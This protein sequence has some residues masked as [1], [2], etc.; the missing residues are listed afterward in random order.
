MLSLADIDL[1]HGV[2]TTLTDPKH[3]TLDWSKIDAKEAN[4]PAYTPVSGEYLNQLLKEKL[5][6]QKEKLI[7][8]QEGKEEKNT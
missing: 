7:K 5:A 4:Q 6:V 2:I 1:L 8:A 3:R